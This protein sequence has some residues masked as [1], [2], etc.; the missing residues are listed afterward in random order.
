MTCPDVD[1]YVAVTNVPSDKFC[2]KHPYHNQ[3]TTSN[4]ITFWSLKKRSFAVSWQ[5][6]RYIISKF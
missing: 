4:L 3:D 5:Q 1:A 2:L 6:K